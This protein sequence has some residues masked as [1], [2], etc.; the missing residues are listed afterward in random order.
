MTSSCD[1]VLGH[2]DRLNLSCSPKVFYVLYAA[3]IHEDPPVKAAFDNLEAAE[4]VT[5]SSLEHLFDTLLY[6]DLDF[7]QQDSL[8]DT[9]KVRTK[10]IRGAVTSSIGAASALGEDGAAASP[11]FQTLVTGL[12][13]AVEETKRLG[14]DIQSLQRE[15]MTDPLTGIAN[16]RYFEKQLLSTLSKAQ[17]RA[18]VAYLDIDRFK[19]INDGHGH[20]IGDQVL[21]LIAGRLASKVKDPDVICRY[22]GEEFCAIFF[23]D[24]LEACL[25]DVEGLRSDIHAQGIVNSKTGVVIGKITLSGGVTQIQAGDDLESV[26]TRADALLYQSKG[27]GRNQVTS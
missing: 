3:F 4:N 23:R 14:K 15:L 10:K 7:R 26:M 16:R 24:S 1:T 20:Q 6:S 2:M 22:G 27:N 25:E 11:N 21:R 8:I 13:V 12:T 18:Y 5:N 9:A 19:A 17:Q